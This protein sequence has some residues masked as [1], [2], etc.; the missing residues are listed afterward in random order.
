MIKR[1]KS[2]FDLA[3][4]VSKQERKKKF[5]FTD[6]LRSLRHDQESKKFFSFSHYVH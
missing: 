6:S 4:M 3:T 2:F 1:E 5:F